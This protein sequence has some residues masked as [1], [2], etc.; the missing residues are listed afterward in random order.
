MKSSSIKSTI[1]AS[2][3][4][5]EAIRD[6]THINLS[7]CCTI[8]FLKHGKWDGDAVGYMYNDDISHFV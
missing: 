1:F 8:A 6:G 4:K 5:Y 2:V 3:P 7:L